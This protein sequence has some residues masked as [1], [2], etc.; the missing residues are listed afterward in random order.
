[1]TLAKVPVEVPL[2]GFWVLYDMA[3]DQLTRPRRYFDRYGDTFTFRFLGAP[4]HNSRDPL[5]FD[6]VL[7]KKHKSFEKDEITRGLS[8]IL[9][10]GLLTSGG[11]HWRQHRKLMQPHF[12]PKEL[13]RYV[14]IF[15]DEAEREC[16]S[17]TGDTV[18]LHEAMVNFT[19]RVALRAFFGESADEAPGFERSMDAVMAYF[20]GIFGTNMALPLWLPT[21]TN[22]AFKRARKHLRGAVQNLVDRYREGT[23]QPSILSSLMAKNESGELSDTDLID[24]GITLLTA[25]HETTALA[26]TYTLGLLAAHPEIQTRLRAEMLEGDLP[27]TLDEVRRGPLLHQVIKESLRL[28]TV[29]WSVGREALED[30]E[31]GGHLIRKGEPIYLFLWEAHHAAKFFPDPESFRPERWTPE[32]ESALPRQLYIPFGGGPRVCIGNQ[33]ALGELVLA[34][35]VFLRHFEFAALEPRFA[36]KLEPSV[37]VRPKSAVRVRVAKR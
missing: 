18:D 3:R 9:G 15:V 2:P 8:K 1:M 37:T 28:Y 33:F 23:L 26:L 10:S 35:Q 24:E 31:V 32:F 21:P 14:P 6:E 22:L 30:V 17:W 16:A 7:V 29:A 19:A 34:L 27:R 13:D 12:V 5:V 36:P 20:R 4:V 25:G 11:Q